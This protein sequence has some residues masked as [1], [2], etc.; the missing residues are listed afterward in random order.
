M[1]SRSLW[2]SAIELQ[3][4]MQSENFQFCFIGGI[5]VQRWGE[6]RVTDDLDLTLLL[7][8]GEEQTVAKRILSRYQSRHP[9]PLA[10]VL[11]ARILLLQDI[12][13]T[14]IDLSLGGMPYEERMIARS[15]DWSVP[16]HGRLSTCSAEDLV[17]LKSFASRPRDWIDVEKTVIRQSK[18]LNRNLIREELEV[19]AALKEEPEILTQLETI[20]ETHPN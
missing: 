9:R 1:L 12:S 14:D 7:K 3:S 18:N 6:P 5:A 15:S 17:V 13:G 19:L 11:E 8:F 20:F 10:F 16:G 4:Y 2:D